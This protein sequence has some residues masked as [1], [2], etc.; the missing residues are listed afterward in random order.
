MPLFA[1]LQ[2]VQADY[3]RKALDGSMFTAGYATEMIEEITGADG[4]LLLLPSSGTGLDKWGDLGLL[5]EAGMAFA[6]NVSSQEI[7]SF[8]KT[9]PTR[10]DVT[11]D[12]TDITVVPQQTMARTIAQATGA[13]LAG[14]VPTENGEIIIRKPARTKRRLY[15]GLALGVDEN[16]FGEIYIGRGFPRLEVTSFEGQ[17]FA[18]GGDPVTWGVTYR[19]TL[20]S[21]LGYS[22]SWHF[23]GAGWIPMLVGMGFPAIPPPPPPPV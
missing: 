9:S 14:V 20:D 23:G 12:T 10:T 3:I 8:G 11:D 17:S 7:R 5:T 19:G 15:R 18:S 6:R 22:E 1:D 2:D 21:V 13:N 4:D 16:N